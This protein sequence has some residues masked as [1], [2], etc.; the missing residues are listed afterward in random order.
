MI[1]W[2]QK[3]PQWKNGRC[4]F[5]ADLTS[6]CF[7]W[8][9]WEYLGTL[10]VRGVSELWQYLFLW[11]EHNIF[12]SILQVLLKNCFIKITSTCH[13]VMKLSKPR[14]KPTAFWSLEYGASPCSYT[15]VW[16]WESSDH[17]SV[18]FHVLVSFLLQSLSDFWACRFFLSN[19]VCRYLWDLGR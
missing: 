8:M 10:C 13:W 2:Q 15:L 4:G 19:K 6:Y 16:K 18:C 5:M 14:F 1:S 17:L 3:L 9:V 11:F 12:T 7:P